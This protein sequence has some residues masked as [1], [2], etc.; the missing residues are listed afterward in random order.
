MGGG[1]GGFYIVTLTY[2]LRRRIG[3][4]L[5]FRYLLLATQFL[6]IEEGGEFS[7]QSIQTVL[8]VFF[9]VT[10]AVSFRCR[11]GGG[12]YCWWS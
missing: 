10:T 6:D 8:C 4:F 12:G 9:V 2:D 5:Y 11:G 1:G 7:R 3:Y